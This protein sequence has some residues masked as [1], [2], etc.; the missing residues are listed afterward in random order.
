MPYDIIIGRDESDKKKFEGKGL[1]RLGK[2]FVKMG[3]Y[4]SLSNN[5]FMD[6]ARSHVVLVAGKRGSGKS[7]TLGTIAEEISNLSDE[8]RKNIAPLIFDTMGIFWTMKY[9]NEKEKELL[10]E[11]D[12]KP[13]KLPVRVFVPYGHFEDYL[14]RGIPVDAPFALKVSEMDAEDWVLLFGLGIIDPVSVLIQRVIY[15]LEEK[16]DFDLYDIVEKIKTFENA[17]V[18]DKNAAIGL[19]EAASTWG[20]FGNKDDEETDITSLLKAG[21]TSVIDLSV[22]N[23]VGAFNVRALVIGLVSRKL[24]NERMYARKSEEIEAVRQGVDYLSYS[25]DFLAYIRS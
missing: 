7:Y 22:Y 21:E 9:E 2:G 1:L 25:S 11:W 15:S 20:V 10:A 6:V 24:F 3:Q 19:F 14:H 13:L 18:Q 8:S 17:S 23:S 5:I 4:N 12:L 16:G